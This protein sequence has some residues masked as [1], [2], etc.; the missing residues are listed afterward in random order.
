MRCG[1]DTGFM[2]SKIKAICKLGQ[3]LFLLLATSQVANGA[4]T[5][6]LTEGAGLTALRTTNNALAD[7]FRNGFEAAA[8]KWSAEFV[9][10]I[11]LNITIDVDGSLRD[12]ILGGA[13]PNFVVHSYTD[14]RTAIIADQTSATDASVAANLPG[15]TAIDIRTNDRSGAVVIDTDTTARNSFLRISRSNAKAIGLLSANDAAEDANITFNETFNF[16][17]DQSDGI[18]SGQFDFVG[19]AAH[20]IGH[21]MGFSS[22]VDLVD[23]LSLAGPNVETDINGLLPGIGELDDF[24]LFTTLDLLRY[25]NDSLAEGSDVLDLAF[26]GTPFTSI[27][28]GLTS[29]AAM[30]TGQFNG[31]PATKRQASHFA[32]NAHIFGPTFTTGSTRLISPTDIIAIDAIGFDLAAAV[33]VPEPGFAIAWIAVS[34]VLVRRR[35]R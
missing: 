33:A 21:A 32:S 23:Q 19:I 22:G 4:L 16:D 26:G 6:N 29:L 17:F 8:A 1:D 30:T 18:T 9:D 35:R 15:G 14:V 3:A 20:E 2:G 31:N 10:S 27:D 24:A 7:D 34:S 11:M 13:D 5:F 28:G 12:S 25:S